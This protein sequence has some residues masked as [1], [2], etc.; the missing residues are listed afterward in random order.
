MSWKAVPVAQVPEEIGRQLDAIAMEDAPLLEASVLDILNRGLGFRKSAENGVCLLGDGSKIPMM[1]YGLIEY[2]MGLDLSGF[3]LLELGGGFS[4]EFWSARV[5]SV[6]TLETDPAW[7][8][9]LV[10]GNFPNTEIRVTEAERIAEDMT[11]LGRAFD[12]VIVDAAT[13]RYRCAKAALQ[14][15]KPGGFIL[16][17]NADWY[18]NTTAML[19]DADLI[20]VDF[21]DF[22]PLRWYRCCT[23]LF[24]HKDFRARPRDRRLPR[25]LIGG[26]DIGEVNAWDKI[27]D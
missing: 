8:Q 17:D 14:I 7:A 18:P 11:G 25:P 4:T 21:S 15:L 20:Q 13:N 9:T 5:K 10:T 2:V 23:S 24:L 27:T 3:D 22:R 1:S 12:A 19:R 16:L 6:T 26:K